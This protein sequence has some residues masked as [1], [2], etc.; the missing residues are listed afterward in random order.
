MVLKSPVRHPRQ[1]FSTHLTRQRPN[2]RSLVGSLPRG[3]YRR[4]CPIVRLGAA[5][6]RTGGRAVTSNPVDGLGA[7]KIKNWTIEASDTVTGVLVQAYAR[8]NSTERP[9]GVVNDFVASSLG[10]AAGLP[11]PPGFLIPLSGNQ[12]GYVSIAFTD[13]GDRLPPVIP[14]RLA[15]E[16]PW[17]ATGIIAFDQ[18]I[19]NTDRHDENLA[20]DRNIGL[21]VFDHDLSLINTPADG[22]PETVLIGARDDEVKGHL[23]ARHLT[24]PGHFAEWVARIAAITKNEIDRVVKTCQDAGLLGASDRALLVDFLRHRQERVL[25]YVARTADEYV[26]VSSWPIEIGGIG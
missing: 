14:R 20:Y 10:L 6:G 24:T 2:G 18:W 1:P 16:R 22:R 25:H 26:R 19:L 3:R 5:F 13:R 21:A 4:G 15:E 8:Q 12:Q 23:L 11:I 7:F 9:F 17:D